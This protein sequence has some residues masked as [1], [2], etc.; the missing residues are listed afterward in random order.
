MNMSARYVSYIIFL[1]GLLPFLLPLSS[2]A[3]REAKEEEEKRYSMKSGGTVK[4]IANEGYV[5][6]STWD[7]SEV[8]LTMTKYARGKSKREASSSLKVDVE[9][10]GESSKDYCRAV[11]I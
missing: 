3:D 6:I 7:R 4:I 10:I 9:G 2:L 8:A 11:F 1:T 5:T